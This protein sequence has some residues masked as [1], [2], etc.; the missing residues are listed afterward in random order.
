MKEATLPNQLNEIYSLET[1]TL[2][3]RLAKQM[4]H[5]EW[6]CDECKLKFLELKVKRNHWFISFKIGESRR[7]CGET[8]KPR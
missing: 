2:Q 1:N 8:W 7:G 5:L 6:L 3:T 4:R